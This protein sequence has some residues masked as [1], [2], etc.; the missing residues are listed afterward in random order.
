MF[1]I[2]FQFIVNDYLEYVIEVLDNQ[3]NK[4]DENGRLLKVLLVVKFLVEFNIYID[5]FFFGIL[6]I[7]YY[8]FLLLFD[9]ERNECLQFDFLD[10]CL[11]VLLKK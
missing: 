5:F 10:D 8:L 11:D 2:I 7:I 9:I 6:E 1:V 4:L 3:V